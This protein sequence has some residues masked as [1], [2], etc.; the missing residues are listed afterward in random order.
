MC[1]VQP[2]LPAP[3]GRSET[4][5]NC[6]F[7][8]IFFLSPIHRHNSHSWVQNKNNTFFWF[9]ILRACAQQPR[10]NIT[11]IIQWLLCVPRGVSC[12]STSFNWTKKTTNERCT[13]VHQQMS[14]FDW[15][16]K[17]IIIVLKYNNTSTT[18]ILCNIVIGI[19]SSVFT[20]NFST[21]FHHSFPGL[22]VF[23][24]PGRE[25]FN[26]LIAYIVRRIFFFPF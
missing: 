24:G 1:T 25:L 10:D 17:K 4:R 13:R 18:A 11:I 21:L 19:F 12:P 6:R 15:W 14:M 5:Y 16:K 20:I 2:D 22:F 23:A 26:Y 7:G 9:V 3:S 8:R